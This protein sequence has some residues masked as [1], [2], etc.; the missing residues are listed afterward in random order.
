[1]SRISYINE[2][3]VTQAMNLRDFSWSTA[4]HILDTP[5]GTVAVKGVE[6]TAFI[7]DKL[8]DKYFPPIKEE[9]NEK[10]NTI[11]K[12]YILNFLTFRKNI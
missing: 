12:A 8:I 5:Y 3:I 7:V 2:L 9:E 10:L 6:N 4:N 1:M 11:G